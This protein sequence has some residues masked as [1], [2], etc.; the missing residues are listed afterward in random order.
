MLVVPF[1]FSKNH[2]FKFFKNNKYFRL[3]SFRKIKIQHEMSFCFVPRIELLSNKMDALQEQMIGT[4]G[5]TMSHSLTHTHSS[6]NLGSSIS[7]TNPVVNL[8]KKVNLLDEKVISFERLVSSALPY[9][10][11]ASICRSWP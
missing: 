4:G 2:L 5:L 6:S 1:G 7:S 8:E 11:W 10:P 3:T 9:F